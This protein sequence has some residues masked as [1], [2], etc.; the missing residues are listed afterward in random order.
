MSHTQ[1]RLGRGFSDWRA[2]TWGETGQGVLAV[3]GGYKFVSPHRTQSIGSHQAAYLVAPHRYTAHMQAPY[4]TGDC[5]SCAHG[6]GAPPSNERGR[7]RPCGVKA[8]AADVQDTLCLADGDGLLL[9]VVNA[10]V[11]H[12]S[13]RAKKAEAFFDR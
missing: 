4:T 11:A 5:H 9:Q 13:F 8:G 10:L 2:S 6:L 1:V 3:G 12:L 7:N